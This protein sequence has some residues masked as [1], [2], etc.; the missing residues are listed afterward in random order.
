MVKSG[1][2]NWYCLV[3][4]VCLFLE[5]FIK[6]TKCLILF[7]YCEILFI[8]RWIFI[9]FVAASKPRILEFNDMHCFISFNALLNDTISSNL[10][11]IDSEIHEFK[12]S[13]IC[14]ILVVHKSWNRRLSQF[15]NSAWFD[16][17]IVLKSTNRC[18]Y[19]Y[20]FLKFTVPY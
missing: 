18:D 20:L 19:I 16:H 4:F 10:N 17:V 8:R 15:F 11:F 14:I 12:N 6:N 2:K 1:E 3:Y 7:Y 13:L 9:N 5:S